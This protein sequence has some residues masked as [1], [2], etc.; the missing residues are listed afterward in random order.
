M[1]SNKLKLSKLLELKVD[2]DTRRVK[3]RESEHREFKL[4]VENNNIP[5]FSRTMAAFANKD[6]GVLF[7][8][9]KARPRELLGVEDRDIPDDV[10]FTNFLKEYFQ[11]EILFESETIELLNQK[12]HCLVVKASSK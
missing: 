5:K 4:K 3:N 1:T 7:F 10:V 2:R 6:G 9:I 8:G 12:V 11:P